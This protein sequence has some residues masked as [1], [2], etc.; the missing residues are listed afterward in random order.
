MSEEISV[1][2]LNLKKPLDK[3][4]A[5]E[6]RELVME[7]MPQIVGASGMTKDQLLQEIKEFLGLED[8]ESGGNPYKDQIAS[9]KRK[10][11]ELRAQK[12]EL[13]G[14]E[15]KQE[16]EKYRK[17]IKKIKRLTRRLAAS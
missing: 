8:D 9:C 17:Q 6:L 13:Q 5:K 12:A 10:I 1:E 2:S 4:T 16:R 11:K 15:S 3:M 14:A 7:K